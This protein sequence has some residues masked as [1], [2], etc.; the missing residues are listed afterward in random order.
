MI[1]KMY[2]SSIGGIPKGSKGIFTTELAPSPPPVEMKPKKVRKKKA[3]TPVQKTPEPVQEEKTVYSGNMRI[4]IN[5]SYT[6]L[7]LAIS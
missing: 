5:T 3:K 1:A 4:V 6:Y 2:F 7:A